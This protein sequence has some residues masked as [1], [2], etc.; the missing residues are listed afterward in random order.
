VIGRATPTGVELGKGLVD[1]A[2]VNHVSHGFTVA[3]PSAA[4]NTPRV[5]QP[6]I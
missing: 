3:S 2:L 1:T 5:V 4:V 6:L